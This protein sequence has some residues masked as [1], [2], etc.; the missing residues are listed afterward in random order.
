[1]EE[2]KRGEEVRGTQGLLG[3]GSH[4][5]I[6]AQT[7]VLPMASLLCRHWGRGS[8][9]GGDAIRASRQKEV[10]PSSQVF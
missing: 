1:M 3:L 8:E 9:K 10:E 2:N 4:R 6:W 5:H 7:L